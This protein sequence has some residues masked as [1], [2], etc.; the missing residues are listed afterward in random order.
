MTGLP[1]FLLT[2]R[3]RSALILTT[4]VGLGLGGT[5]VWVHAAN[6][7]PADKAAAPKTKARPALTV[8]VTSLQAADWPL[9]ISAN[10]NLMAW[11]EAV[12]GAE[13]GGLRLLDVLVN[14][15]DNV[16]RGQLLARLQSESV[17]ADVAASRANLAEAQ[18]VLTEARANADRARQ[19]QPGGAMSTQQSQQAFTAE[20]TAAA[21]LEALKARLS[22]DELRLSQTRITALDD[23]VISARQASV[24]A[25]VQPGQELFRL[26]RQRRLEWR[27]EV[28]ATE[29]VRIQPGTQVSLTPAGGQP[30][31]GKVRMVAPT[32]DPATRNGLVYVD[33]PA[34]GSARAGM[35]AK[36]DFELGR[37]A[38]QTLPQS[39]V[40]LRDGF[41][42]VFQVGG[43][44]KVTQ[45]KVVTGRRQ[46]D[47]I[48]ITAGLPST[49]KV[50]ASGGAFLGDGDGVRVVES[51]ATAN[52]AQPA[53]AH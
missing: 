35:F 37:A 17:S 22:A 29:L 43:D 2:P 15:G 7:T 1:A 5:A 12:I 39:A 50:V 13:A 28:P 38:A 49:A 26:I 34:N 9:T 16:R 8:T 3:H 40:L 36:G 31:Q 11:Q 4:L 21:R 10:G 14:V 41:S 53:A 30:I 42:Y 18:A 51:P 27:A 6:D 33:L 19:L 46:G 25:V 47:R 48:E 24:G 23:G 45:T 44:S 32:V 20:Q 52:T